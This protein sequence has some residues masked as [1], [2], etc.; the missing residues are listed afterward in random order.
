MLS[1][2]REI[3][4]AAIGFTAALA[5]PFA[6]HALPSTATGRISVAQVMEMIEKADSSPIARQTL[7]AYVAGVGETAGVIVDTIGNGARSC[8]KSFSLDTGAVRAALEA[9]APRQDSWSQTPATP[10][11]VADMVKRAGCRTTD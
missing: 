11:I 1:F 5:T 7:V 2:N 6:A 9:G 4:L 10:L 3:T 8:K